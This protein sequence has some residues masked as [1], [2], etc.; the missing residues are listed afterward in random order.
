MSSRRLSARLSSSV[1]RITLATSAAV[2]F[3]GA[4]LIWAGSS[5]AL[6]WM[7][8]GERA[9][10][11]A[12]AETAAARY[13]G[14]GLEALIDFVAP[15]GG[16]FN[17]LEHLKAARAEHEI[18]AVVRR[19][20]HAPVAGFAGLYGEPGWS[21]SELDYDIERPA[22]S[23]RFDLDDEFHA[24]I[25]LFVPETLTQIRE[26]AT[27]ATLTIAILAL[28]LGGVLG[29]ILS[30]AVYRRLDTLSA[31]V[32]AVAGGAL[33]RRLPLSG[34]G[35]EFERLSIDVNAMLDRLEVLARNIEQVSVGVAHDLKTPLSNIGGRLQLIARDL[36]DQDAVARHVDAAERHIASLVRVFDA[37][38]RLGEVE[39]GSR[40]AGF[41]AVDLS[42][43]MADL[44]ESFTPVFQD[45]DKSLTAQ[46]APGLTLQGD[47]ALLVQ[48]TSNLLENSLD[49]ARDGAVAWLTLG[50]RNGAL[51]LEIGDDGPGVPAGHRVRLFER[52]YRLDPSRSTPG[53]GLGLSLVKA[54]AD[55]HDGEIEIDPTSP[56]LVLR[57]SFATH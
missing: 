43:V 35:D 48:M 53:N 30:G 2:A 40:K 32:A 3:G 24:T 49:H 17:T 22:L 36:E 18:I 23:Y 12:G 38:L 37:L 4:A 46:I 29:L 50:R 1:F 52:F 14:A 56:G 25:A 54:I 55:L 39:A 31:T 6:W 8:G 47:E 33:D 9:R 28:P 19:H 26:T 13:H 45:A 44:A 57:I 16:G 10:I 34:S 20:D 41:G 21:V 42:A 7:E 15:D 11:A 27:I 5:A 51:C